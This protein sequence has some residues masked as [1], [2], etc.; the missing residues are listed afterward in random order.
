MNRSERRT[1]M[2]ADEILRLHVE[3]LEVMR[4]DSSR[5]RRLAREAPNRT[6]RVD[7]QLARERAYDAETD[8]LRSEIRASQ[9]GVRANV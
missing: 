5:R 2:V 8:R 9:G 4:A 6:R 3:S 1:E 7:A